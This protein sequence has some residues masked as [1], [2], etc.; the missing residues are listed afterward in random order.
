MQ[1]LFFLLS[2]ESFEQKLDFFQENQKD[3]ATSKFFE[4]ERWQ[5]SGHAISRKTYDDLMNHFID[6][7]ILVKKLWI[8]DQIVIDPSKIKLPIM[9]VS[10]SKDKL[11][12][13]YSSSVLSGFGDLFEYNSGHI[14]YLVG[15][16]RKQFVEDLAAWIENLG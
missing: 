5:F 3:I 9:I 8:V 6:D 11:V 2:P 13:T 16:Q 4:I 1:I 15:S 7:N 12:P 10:G 14:G